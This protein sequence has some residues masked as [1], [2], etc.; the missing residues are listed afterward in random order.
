MKRV[1]RIDILTLGLNS[2]WLDANRN[3]TR[4]DQF[5]YIKIQPKTLDLSKRLWGITTEFVWFIPRSLVLRS[6]VLG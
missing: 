1:R 3:R 4:I 2:I 5:R 6:I